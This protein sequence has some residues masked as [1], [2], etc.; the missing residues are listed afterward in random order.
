MRRA[1]NHGANY[2]DA[3]SIRNSINI[4]RSKVFPLFSHF[5]ALFNA[6]LKIHIG[7]YFVSDVYN[8]G[9]IFTNFLC[10]ASKIVPAAMQPNNHFSS[11]S[12]R[13]AMVSQLCTATAH[14]QTSRVRTYARTRLSQ[15]ISQRVRYTRAGSGFDS[16]DKMSEQIS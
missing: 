10:F 6:A 7:R 1:L 2:Q 4:A 13:F 3:F 16:I 14:M 11:H 5:S 9:A 8:N 12:S 15:F